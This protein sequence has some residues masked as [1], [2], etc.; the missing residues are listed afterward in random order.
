MAQF[1][2]KESKV[3]SPWMLMY[4]ILILMVLTEGILCQFFLLTIECDV[5][6]WGDYHL[7]C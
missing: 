4:L 6:D 3:L 7:L 2:I 5:S 1:C